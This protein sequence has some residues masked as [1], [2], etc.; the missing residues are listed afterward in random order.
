MVVA[1]FAPLN[2]P[3]VLHDLP[4]NYAQRIALYDGEGNVSARYHVDKF[5]DFIDLEEVDDED[6]KMWL[7][8]QSFYGEAKKWYKYFP[9][10]SIRSFARFQTIFLEIWDDKQIPLQVLSQYNNLKKGGF[11]SV[12]EFSS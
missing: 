7:F 11:E 8:A 12:H 10:R 9:P 3:L 6:V 4:M 1:R 5:D 2:L